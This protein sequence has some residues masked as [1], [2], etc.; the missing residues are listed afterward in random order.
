MGGLGEGGRGRAFEWVVRHWI[1]VV[2]VVVVVAVVVDGLPLMMG[3]E[4][5]VRWLP[6]RVG[7]A[8]PVAAFPFVDLL[9]EGLDPRLH[10][11]F[12]GRAMLRVLRPDLTRKCNREIKCPQS[13]SC[14]IRKRTNPDF[15]LKVSVQYSISKHAFGFECIPIQI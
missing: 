8:P 2:I 5:L 12:V 15:T 6:Y 1:I 7:R 13:L 9:G 10:R 3:G 4:V 11:V 14:K